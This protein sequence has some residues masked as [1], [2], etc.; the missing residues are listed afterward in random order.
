MDNQTLLKRELPKWPLM[1][2]TG[3]PV[4]IEQAKEIIRRTDHFF[5]WFHG[6]DYELVARVQNQLGMPVKPEYPRTND[7]VALAAYRAELS[8]A[9][10]QLKVWLRHWGY[11]HTEYVTNEWISTSFIDGPYGWCHPDGSIDFA[12]NIGKW[13]HVHEVLQEWRVLATAFPFMQ[14]GI[15]L[16][17]RSTA[18]DDA[19]PVVSMIVEG[20][21]VTLV[22]PSKLDV[23]AGHPAF[24]RVEV[25]NGFEPTEACGIPLT[26]F[27]DWAQKLVPKPQ[28]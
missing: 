14:V 9:Y 20:P 26:W 4:T 22:D 18:Q 10:D 16:Y 15:T 1:K 11:V 3:R 6:N 24:E 12:G 19:N 8:A 2:V 13:P 23:H 21:I 7:P 28:G 17:D 5:L 27:D 25:D